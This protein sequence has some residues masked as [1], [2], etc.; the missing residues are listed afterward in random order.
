MR[1]PAGPAWLFCPA[2]RPDRYAKALDR[3][4]VV[5]L[6][7]EDAVSPD[8]KPAARQSLL[9]TAFDAE[10]VVVRINAAGTEDHAA[11]LA[12]LKQTAV[13]RVML[14]KAE[15]L[16]DLE[17]L[18]GYEVVAL[19]ETPRGVVSAPRLAQHPA[20]WGLMWG[21]EDLVASA[22]GRASRDQGGQYYDLAR[23]ARAQVF[24]AARAADAE[25]LDAVY[26]DIKDSAGLRA[27]TAE[28]VA[29]GFTG[30][31]CIHPDQ[32]RIVREV[33]R[34]GRE[35]VAWARRI[36]E[37]GASGGV[38]KVDGRMVDGPLIRQAER[39]IA[40]DTAAASHP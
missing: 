6:D 28:A 31:A 8:R 35:Q 40:A 29:T 17:A 7:L 38:V 2:D 26:L 39:I 4:D 33:F 13:T 19:C 32:I 36:L 21:A 34:P 14:P 9:E 5:I 11:D 37:A 24:L 27:E 12:A 18:E 22:G 25:V 15:E 10:R 3:A 23:T 1:F 20:V 30:K 16:D